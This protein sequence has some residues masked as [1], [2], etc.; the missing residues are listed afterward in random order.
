MTNDEIRMMNQMQIAWN[1]LNDP[2]ESVRFLDLRASAA[3]ALTGGIA[4]TFRR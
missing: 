1:G 3:G 2:W 4:Y